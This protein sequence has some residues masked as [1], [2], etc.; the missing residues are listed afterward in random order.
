MLEN[1]R[2]LTIKR[3]NPLMGARPN[4]EVTFHAGELDWRIPRRC[5]PDE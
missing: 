1:I 4:Q 5:H 3:S 2:V